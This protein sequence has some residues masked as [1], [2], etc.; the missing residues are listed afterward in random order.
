VNLTYDHLLH[1]PFTGIGRQDC[2]QLAFDFYRDNFQI[3]VPHI[4]RPSNWS[5]DKLDLMRLLPEKFGFEKVFDWKPKDLR[6]GDI[7]CIA[8]GESNPNH[9]AVYIGEGEMIHHLYGRFSSQE[10]YRDFWQRHTSF[11][12][13]HPDVPD[14]RPHHPDVD[15]MEFLRARNAPPTE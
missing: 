1:K 3:S 7:L 10:T 4:A 15:L 14:L 12:I 9:F 11:V 13:R 6:P 2:F 5:S 8:I